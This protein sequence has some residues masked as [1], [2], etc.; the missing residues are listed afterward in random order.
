LRPQLEGRI[1]VHRSGAFSQ[2]KTSMTERWRE[3]WPAVAQRL[4]AFCPQYREGVKRRRVGTRRSGD[5][6]TRSYPKSL[7]FFL[8]RA[9]KVLHPA[10]LMDAPTPETL[11]KLQSQSTL[12]GNRKALRKMLRTHPQ[13]DSLLHPELLAW[14]QQPT[15][16]DSSEEQLFQRVQFLHPSTTRENLSVA[17]RHLRHLRQAPNTPL[18]HL[19]PVEVAIYCLVERAMAMRRAVLLACGWDAPTLDALLEHF[20]ASREVFRRL[21]KG[22][23]A[24]WKLE[25]WLRLSTVFED[26]ELAARDW[27]PEAL[28]NGLKRLTM[29]RRR[30]LAVEYLR[31]LLRNRPDVLEAF[32]KAGERGVA[33]PC[34]LSRL[35]QHSSWYA[36]LQEELVKFESVASRTFFADRRLRA[37]RKQFA[38]FLVRLQQVVQP[39]ELQNF[40]STASAPQLESAVR[41]SLRLIQPGRVKCHRSAHHALSAACEA[42]HFLKGSLRPRLGCDPDVL[43]LARLLRGLENRR[44]LAD[45]TLRR[46][47]NDDEIERLIKVARDPAEVL[48]ITLLREV[49]LRSSALCH[50]KYSMLLTEDH[51]PRTQCTVPEKGGKLRAF[52]T[53]TKMRQDIQAMSSFL[54]S[55]YPDDLLHNCFVL[56]L[57]NLSRPLY[58]LWEIVRR[59]ARS[60]GI[61]GV[62]V[63]PHAF[64]HTLVQRLVQVGNS[65]EVVSKFMGHSSVQTTASFYFVPT[66]QQLGETLINPFSEGFQDKQLQRQ[67]HTVNQKLADQKLDLCRNVLDIAL[68]E[69]DPTTF[70][71]I[72]ARLPSLATIRSA[73]REPP[74]LPEP[75]VPPTPPDPRLFG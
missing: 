34:Q 1:D 4:Q 69:C 10:S 64:R 42:L 11:A 60:A 29:H 36:Q 68:G 67:E 52:R 38:R 51:Q 7:E 43:T 56:N 72:C 53:S 9:L 45:P 54:R 14:F 63:H 8:Q 35:A 47:F 26:P 37:L 5:R 66:P 31:Q 23:P 59:L 12:F 57:S 74:N 58:G 75:L 62:H 48:M 65:I 32:D 20:R 27:G 44:A 61:V 40:L 22:K 25:P 70:Q 30:N 13:L 16:L 18:G 50:L 41:D 19:E 28:L 46:S 71:R 17:L 21:R 73:L 39:A 2:E 15:L 3:A 55:L 6:A 24:S 33:R 49:G